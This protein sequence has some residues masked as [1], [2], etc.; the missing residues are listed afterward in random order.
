MSAG[1][2]LASLAPGEF[3]SVDDSLG[4]EDGAELAG[5]VPG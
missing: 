5:V 2:A 3:V 1:I 4:V